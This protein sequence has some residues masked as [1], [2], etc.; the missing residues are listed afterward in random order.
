[1]VDN[2]SRGHKKLIN[3]KSIFYKLN[4]NSKEKIKN[5]ISKYRIDTIIH[6]AALMR[7]DEFIKFPKRYKINNIQEREA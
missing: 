7:V 1:M 3:K 6:L 5:I 4:I 2:L